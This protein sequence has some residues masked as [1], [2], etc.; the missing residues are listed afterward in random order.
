MTHRYQLGARVRLNL[1]FRRSDSADGPF[2]VV[3]QLPAASDGEHQYRVKSAREHYERVV[4]ESDLE[5]A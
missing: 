3:R 5:R 4:K 2:E 1:G